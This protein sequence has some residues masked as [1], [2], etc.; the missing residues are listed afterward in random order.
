MSNAFS[1][2]CVSEHDL[3]QKDG[4]DRVKSQVADDRKTRMDLS[5]EP[6]K[7]PIMST[8]STGYCS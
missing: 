6:A 1:F 3:L 8:A 7:C 4:G 5:I 2:L